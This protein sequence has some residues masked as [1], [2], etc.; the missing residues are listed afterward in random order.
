M[1]RA[2]AFRMTVPGAVIFAILASMI[3]FR[4]DA[5][6]EY[7]RSNR[8]PY[9]A[10]ERLPKTDLEVPGGIIHVAFAPG[11]SVA[12]LETPQLSRSP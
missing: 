12:R 7:T 10:F 9:E 4:A 3:G 11:E 8:M 2:A 1:N 6:S 5:Q